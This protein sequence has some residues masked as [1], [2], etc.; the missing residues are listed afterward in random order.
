MACPSPVCPED[1]T[2]KRTCMVGKIAKFGG[3][4]AATIDYC[5]Y[6]QGTSAKQ[7]QNQGVRGELI[8][9]QGVDLP[10]VAGTTG[11]GAAS[12]DDLLEGEQLDVK[13]LA[14]TFSDTADLNSRI[15]K[16]VWHQI[17]SFPPGEQPD[18]ATLSAICQAF[19]ETFGMGENQAVAFRHTDKRHEHIHLIINRVNTDGVNTSDKDFNYERTGDFCRQMEQ[20]HN[21]T[22]TAPMHSKRID[23]KLEAKI[24]SVDNR[25]RE[26]I[27]TVLPRCDTLSDLSIQLRKQYGT[28]TSLSRGITFTDKQTGTTLKGSAL[29]RTYSRKA[30]T[31]RLETYRPGEA[32]QAF[33]IRTANA[34]DT[35][36]SQGRCRTMDELETCLAEQR[37]TLDEEN[38]FVF[39]GARGERIRG[40]DMGRQYSEHA[41]KKLLVGVKDAVQD[42]IGQTGPG[43]T[44]P[45]QA[46]T[47]T[48]KDKTSGKGKTSGKADQSELGSDSEFIRACLDR[49]TE[50]AT[51]M[52]DFK[53]RVDETTGIGISFETF[54]DKQGQ[55]RTALGITRTYPSGQQRRATGGKLGVAYSYPRI[56]ERLLIQAAIRAGI[57]LP[58]PAAQQEASGVLVTAL[59][60]SGSPAA[61]RRYID[62]RT[63]YRLYYRRADSGGKGNAIHLDDSQAGQESRTNGFLLLDTRQ[64]PPLVLDGKNVGGALRQTTLLAILAERERSNVL[65]APLRALIDE[66]IPIARQQHTGLAGVS[67]Y[68]SS[69]S[70][71]QADYGQYRPGGEPGNA[72]ERHYHKDACH[73]ERTPYAHHI[74]YQNEL[75]RS[76]TSDMMGPA[77]SPRAL[78]LRLE[79]H[80]KA[81][82]V[83]LIDKA[84]QARQSP[85]KTVGEQTAKSIATGTGKQPGG[86]PV[87]QANKQGNGPAGTG[88][89]D[90]TGPA[91]GKGN[92][93]AKPAP[94]P[95]QSR[96]GPGLDLSGAGG[97]AQGQTQADLGKLSKSERMYEQMMQVKNQTT[98]ET[99]P[100]KPGASAGQ[101][102]K[103]RGAGKKRKKQGP[104]PG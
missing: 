44:V 6:E 82:A 74:R 64:T 50:S 75:K 33:G 17:F 37:V 76:V 15:Q 43:Q 59:R 7:G 93:A 36:M 98:T 3:S 70:H 83:R 48:G 8:Y 1:T 29:G 27:D 32:D 72:R 30:L 31:E 51:S 80:D 13:T 87:G 85:G 41:L 66:A 100:V 101:V 61:F 92:F 81:E 14:G 89:G 4:F 24:S 91:A 84:D 103:G 23:G 34:I 10:A 71:Y 19:T 22:P 49:A 90:Q 28:V 5:Y 86:Q 65:S 40:F 57:P 62:T 35:F 95:G 60:Q 53:R 102:E 54:T 21:L 12:A 96:P 69:R 73:C 55:A 78:L 58:T 63:P 47:D 16:P 79:G 2:C 42:T 46:T 38:G 11:P 88:R 94:Q 39:C 77:Y 104:S 67:A 68:V 26:Q 97:Q 52:A 25:L 9:C 18:A 20:S 56:Q 45:G 99:N